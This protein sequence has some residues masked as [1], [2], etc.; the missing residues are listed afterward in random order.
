MQAECSN[1]HK[2]IS[3]PVLLFA[4]HQLRSSL[5]YAP[6]TPDIQAFQEPM[7]HSIGLPSWSCSFLGHRPKISYG[8]FLSEEAWIFHHG[9]RT[10]EARLHCSSRAS[11]TTTKQACRWTPNVVGIFK[12][13]APDFLIL[14]LSRQAQHFGPHDADTGDSSL[15]WET[16]SLQAT[17]KFQL[18][19]KVCE[20]LLLLLYVLLL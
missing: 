4:T 3:L 15:G 12:S 16:C 11:A 1:L 13:S 20:F 6:Q 2:T 7:Q 9:M 19:G 8:P 17:W 10:G 14:K 5:N 18:L